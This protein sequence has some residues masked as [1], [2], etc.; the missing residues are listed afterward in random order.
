MLKKLCL[1]SA[2]LALFMSLTTLALPRIGRI[3]R[4]VVSDVCQHPSG[5]VVSDAKVT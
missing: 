1:S 3:V 2:L 5:A 4:K